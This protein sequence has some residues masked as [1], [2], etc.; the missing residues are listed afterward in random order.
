MMTGHGAATDSKACNVCG[1]LIDPDSDYAARKAAAVQ[2]GFDA[3]PP[4]KKKNVTALPMHRPYQ[5]YKMSELIADIMILIE[6]NG[7]DD[8]LR[9]IK[10]FVPSWG[11]GTPPL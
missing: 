1:K 8:A 3:P 5:K 10:K 11:L 4:P 2:R 7:G 6:D 9:Q